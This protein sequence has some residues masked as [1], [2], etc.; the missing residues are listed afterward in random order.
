MNQRPALSCLCSMRPSVKRQS[1]STW[2][3]ELQIRLR[4]SISRRPVIMTCHLY[5]FGQNGYSMTVEVDHLLFDVGPIV[6]SFGT[7]PRCIRHLQILGDIS[8]VAQHHLTD[9]SIGHFI[10]LSICSDASQSFF[11]EDLRAGLVSTLILLPKHLG[12]T[13]SGT[14]GLSQSGIKYCT[15]STVLVP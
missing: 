15:P 4:P 11:E 7:L 2:H 14:S 1:P 8:E 6:F 10:E 3:A 12:S 5:E 13:H 9:T